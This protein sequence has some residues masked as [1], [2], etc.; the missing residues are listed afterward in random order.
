MKLFYYNFTDCGFGLF[1]YS[2][3]KKNKGKIILM[4]RSIV[5]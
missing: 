2:E 3:K 4:C 1:W 5:A